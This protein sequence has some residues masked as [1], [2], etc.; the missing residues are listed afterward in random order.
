MSGR[1]DREGE[2]VVS[3][4]NVRLPHRD[5]RAGPLPMRW[6]AL[7]YDECAVSFNTDTKR[8]ELWSGQVGYTEPLAVFTDRE[9]ALTALELL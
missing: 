1:L 6:R 7:A 5:M 2:M 8:Y 9:A 4:C 3:R